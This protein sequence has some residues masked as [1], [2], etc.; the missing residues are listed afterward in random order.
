MCCISSSKTKLF[1]FF[2]LS[3]RHFTNIFLATPF[4]FSKNEDD[5]KLSYEVASVLSYTM[6]LFWPHPSILLLS[7]LLLRYK[8]RWRQTQLQTRNTNLLCL[9]LNWKKRKLCS[10]GKFEPI[11]IIPH[12]IRQELSDIQSD[13]EFYNKYEPSR[14]I[15]YNDILVHTFQD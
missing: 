6:Q 13:S 4:N 12:A 11:N 9:K 8:W 5:A 15:K 1:L 2:Q 7:I 3:L 14:N 10:F